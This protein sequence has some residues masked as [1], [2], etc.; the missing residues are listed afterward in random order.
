MVYL[1]LR[2]KGYVLMT[3]VALPQSFARIQGGKEG[4]AVHCEQYIND[5]LLTP[6]AGRTSANT[7]IECDVD[8]C[9][10]PRRN[11]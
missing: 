3:S 7:E 11:L 10:W 6:N 9:V 5:N 2:F 4:V 8:E 1:W